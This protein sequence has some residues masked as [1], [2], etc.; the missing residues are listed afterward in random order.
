M[1]TNV[2]GKMLTQVR[3]T[4]GRYNML[5]GVNKLVIGFSSGPDS[6]CLLDVLYTLLHN[7]IK[8]YLIYVNH[9]L[10]PKRN[11]R[12]EETLTK[13]YALRYNCG[14]KLVNI[15]VRKKKIGIEAAAR[16]KRYCSLLKY[17]NNVGAQRIALGHNLD[18]VVETFF[19]NLIR[20]SG[21]RGLKSI[22]PVRLPFVRPLINI[23]KGEILQ[24]LRMRKLL[25]S[26]DETNRLLEYR[27]NLLRHKIIPE[28]MKVNPQLHKAIKKTIDILQKDNEYFEKQAERVF[29]RVVRKELKHISID[30]KK[31]LRYNLNIIDR[32]LMH[33]IKQLRG[34]L[35]GFESKHFEA[36]IGLKDKA[37]GKRIS[38]PKGLFAQREFNDIVV[39]STM[40]VRKIEMLVNTEKDEIIF[41]NSLLKVETRSR[42]DWKKRKSNCEVFALDDLKLP[43][44]LRNRRKGDVIETRIGKKKIKKI[45]NEF[46]VPLHNRSSV[47]MLCDQRGVLLIPG[48]VRAFRG[49]VNKKT[50]RLLVVG[51]ERT[52]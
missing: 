3:Q 4:L 43:L 40:P 44:V 32:V 11:L 27:R 14:Y 6:V 50:K 30:T 25:Y 16:E 5:K 31:I 38:L 42:F 46:K 21:T 48:L 52:H 29:K 10:R 47:M 8:F 1:A 26:T 15:K 45:Y 12:R 28:L 49:Y 33:V 35:N 36:I 13:K 24:Y 19:M 7:Q 39:G 17:M 23:K 34:G 37:S 41:G 18:D 20:G 2:K 51:F 9:G 22:P